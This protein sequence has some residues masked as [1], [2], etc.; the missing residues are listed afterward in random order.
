MKFQCQDI[1]APP[2]TVPDGPPVAVPTPSEWG[3]AM[4]ILALVLLTAWRLR[5][6]SAD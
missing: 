1:A 6:F 2:P 5:G 3:A 4:M